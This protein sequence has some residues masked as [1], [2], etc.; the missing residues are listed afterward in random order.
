MGFGA[1]VFSATTTFCAS[2][3]DIGS[4][5]INSLDFLGYNVSRTLSDSLSSYLYSRHNLTPVRIFDETNNTDPRE[6]YDVHRIWGALGILIM[7][8]PGFVMIPLA[9]AYLI[10]GRNAFKETYSEL[11]F[12]AAA[13]TKSNKI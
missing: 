1:E 5:L 7:F 11:Q 13:S 8:F 2:N 6:I 4:D 12:D 10:H 3:F 9:L